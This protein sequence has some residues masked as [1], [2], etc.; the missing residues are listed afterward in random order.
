MLLFVEKIYQSSILFRNIYMWCLYIVLFMCDMK[1]KCYQCENKK[2]IYKLNYLGLDIMKDNTGLLPFSFSFPSFGFGV[3][4]N[5][6]IYKYKC[7][8]GHLFNSSYAMK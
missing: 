8:N 6:Y 2:K 5:A 3:Y 4:H 1:V 7:S